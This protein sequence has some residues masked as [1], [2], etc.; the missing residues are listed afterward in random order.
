MVV[1]GMQPILSKIAASD[2]L[3]EISPAL[4]SSHRI[5]KIFEHA[6]WEPYE[7]VPADSLDNYFKAPLPARVIPLAGRPTRRLDILV[8]QRGR[9]V[10]FQ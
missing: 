2:I 5:L 3:I 6:A 4:T 8:R 9:P 7:I 10:Q 1:N